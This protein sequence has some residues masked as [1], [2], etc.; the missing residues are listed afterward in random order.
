MANGNWFNSWGNGP[1]MS[2]NEIDPSGEEI[3][4]MKILF[5]NSIAVTYRAFREASLMVN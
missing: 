4:S 3:F 2:I 5:G 1:D